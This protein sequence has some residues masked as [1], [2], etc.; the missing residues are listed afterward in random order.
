MQVLVTSPIPSH[1]QNHGNRARVFSLCRTLQSRGYKIHFVYGG[2]EGLSPDQEAAMRAQWEHLYVVPHTPG[3]RQQSHRK[4][5]LIDDWY[6][7]EVSDVT[8]RILN[9]WKIDYCLANYV[10]F[11]RWLEQVPKGI[12]KYLDT[13]DMFANR[14]KSLKKEGINAAW[15]STTPAEEAKAFDRADCVLAIQESE[16]A[17]FRKATRQSVETLGH[18]LPAQF[19]P[20]KRRSADTK[21]LKVGY[22]ASSNP[23]N[24]HSLYHFTK[25]L[26]VRP[27]MLDHFSFHLAGAICTS[28]I[29]ADTPFEKLGFVESVVSFYRDMDI[30]LNPNMG[31]TGLKIKSVEALSYGKPLV[32]TADAMVGIKTSEPF[33]QCKSMDALA[34]AL[35]Q[36]AQ[37]PEAATALGSSGQ[38]AYLAYSDAQA[39]ALDHLFPLAEKTQRTKPQKTETGG[40]EKEGPEKEASEK[41]AAGKEGAKKK[42]AENE[43]GETGGDP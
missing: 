10:W 38:T 14:E 2:L 43:T 35:M 27:E 24:Q 12:P 4:H 41:E 28:D 7:E 22:L 6:V 3:P 37:N 13:H 20:P 42:N 8:A 11:S 15:Y 36:L 39:K 31:G 21:K 33:H 9:I 40:A 19:L 18:Y 16:A 30:I 1:P 26:R 34:D 29:A 5:H 25:A 17:K 23:I 32:A